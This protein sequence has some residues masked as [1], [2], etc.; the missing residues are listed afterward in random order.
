MTHLPLDIFPVKPPPLENKIEHHPDYYDLNAGA[1]IIHV[2]KSKSG[3]GIIQQNELFNPAFNVSDKLDV[4]HIYSPTAAS[5]DPTWRFAVEQ[6]GDTIYSE[7]SDKHLRSILQAQMALPKNQRPNIAIIFDDIATFP[8][9]NKNSLLFQICSQSRHYNIKYLKY[10][11]QQYKMLPPIVRANTDYALISRTTNEKEIADMEFEM[12]SK[13]D[14]KF[15]KLLAQ[16]TGEPYS[17]LYLRLNDVPSTAF[18]N[19][20]KKIYTATFLG[21]LQVQLSL[22]DGKKKDKME[23]ENEN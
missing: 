3:K 8:N 21:D 11:V 15:R 5:G 6:L 19:F 22:G 1:T 20:T 4:I 13:Y 10:I 16:A 12:G 14:N 9:I 7:Y 17:F 2:G 18:K 23:N